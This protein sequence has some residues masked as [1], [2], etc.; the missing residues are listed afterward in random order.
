VSR[1]VEERAADVRRWLVASRTVYEDRARIAPEIARHTGLTLEGA[2]YGFSCLERHVGDGD[3]GSLVAAAGDAERVHVVL[4]AN[5]FVAPLR[6]VAI[7]RAASA[8][9]TVRPSP[10]DPTLARELVR[11]AGDDAVSIVSDRDVASVDRGEIHVYGREPTIAEIRARA[12]PGVTV[13]GHGPGMGVALVTRSGDLAAAA[14]AIATDVVPFD[15]RGCL[16]PRLVMVEGDEG[17]GEALA[18]ALHERLEGW[19]ARVP[20]GELADTERAD[21][22]RWRETVRF[23]GRVWSGAGHVVGFARWGGVAAVPPPGRHV[24]VASLPSLGEI[25]DA[26]APIARHVVIVGT[27]DPARLRGSV[28]RDI[29]VVSLGLMQRPPLDGPVDRRAVRSRVD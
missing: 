11:A 5:V 15:Q 25:E 16:S 27:D 26:L 18:A 24:H 20:R 7:A 17:R 23:V 10:R 14:D 8:R 4:S 6:A 21:A 13:R 19:D 22:A 2:L 3:L 29:R 28:P 1:P 9:V 12:R